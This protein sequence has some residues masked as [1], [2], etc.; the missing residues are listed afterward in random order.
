[1]AGGT[2]SRTH[3]TAAVPPL[4]AFAA[5]WVGL[6]V[7]KRTLNRDNQA[8]PDTG[9]SAS[10][11]LPTTTNEALQEQPTSAV[12]PEIP[13][14]A[15]HAALIALRATA[16]LA[17]RYRAASSK[18]GSRRLCAQATKVRKLV[19]GDAIAHEPTPAEIVTA[20]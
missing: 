1:M 14:D 11:A 18:R 19:L 7:L 3:G 12:W 5:L 8:A 6:G 15:E 20:A 2:Q 13:A 9:Q 16:Q 17:T 10:A 4:A